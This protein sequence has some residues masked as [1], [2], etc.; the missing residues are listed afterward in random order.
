MSVSV[1]FIGGIDS[2]GGAGIL[3]D[4][5]TATAMAA[6][7]R[8]AVTAVTAQTDR[9]VT[10]VHPVPPDDVAAQIKAAG[11]VGAAKIGMLCTAPVVD[12]VAENLP[13]APLV[14]DPVLAS[15]SGHALL[16]AAGVG[17]LLSRLLKRTTLLTP[18]HPELRILAKGLGLPDGADEPSCV[19]ALMRQGCDAVLV[20]GGHSGTGWICEDRLYTQSGQI[21]PFT[22]P[23]FPIELRGTGCH[24][25]SA[26]AVSLA[27]G[28][29]MYAAIETARH[30]GEVRFREAAE[31]I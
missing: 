21:T 4:C 20:K 17:R 27:T 5:A 3:R 13:D 30:L 11:P 12:A 6:T 14:L 15:S 10:S 1:L 2:S 18:N 25:A 16:D 23:R 24:L 31:G 7:P 22:G 26:I 29:D 28:S 19:A 8:V 9:S